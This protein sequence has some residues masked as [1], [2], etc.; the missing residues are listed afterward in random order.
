MTKSNP[1][2]SKALARKM[3]KCPNCLTYISLDDEKCPACK[4]RVGKI[5]K[6]GI[7][8]R[9]VN[10]TSYIRAMLLWV[11]FGLYIWWAFFREK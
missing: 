6:D 10:W 1:A 2:E 11:I 3:K 7:A 9:P 4:S 8:K 5:G